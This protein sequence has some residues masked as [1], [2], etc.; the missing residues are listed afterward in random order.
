MFEKL[1]GSAISKGFKTIFSPDNETI[2]FMLGYLP[3]FL[4]LKLVFT[5]FNT[6]LIN[7]LAADP[8]AVPVKLSFLTSAAGLAFA[9]SVIPI[10]IYIIQKS[11]NK[12]NIN[13]NYYNFLL[14]PNLY[15]VFFLILLTTLILGSLSG[16]FFGLLISLSVPL[17]IS[18][19]TLSAI[20]LFAF[21]LLIRL[22][23]IV[24]HISLGKKIELKKLFR[25]SKGHFWV[26]IASLFVVSIPAILLSMG[27]NYVFTGNVLGLQTALPSEILTSH[28]QQ[29]P[30]G[31][32]DILRA[33]GDFI[34]QYLSLSSIAAL[35]DL[36]KNIV[37]TSDPQTLTQNTGE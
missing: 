32:N 31:L 9:L 30:L 23:F 10:Y 12:T 22:Y 37:I 3:F 18:A 2:S 34:V 7:T 16:L 5:Y 17:V 4:F 24:P 21:Y 36:Y 1:F 8:E 13:N 28:A 26:M 11:T 29:I 6:E 20:G 33:A 27:L 25:A 19:I 14:D 15:R 35:A